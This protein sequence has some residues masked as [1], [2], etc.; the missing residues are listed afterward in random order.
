LLAISSVILVRQPLTAI[1]MLT[2]AAGYAFYFPLILYLSANFSFHWALL[3]AVV[4][5]GALLVNYARWLLPGNFAMLGAAV[6]LLLYQLFPT[7]AAFAGWNRG[8]VLLCLG[9]VTLAVLINLQNRAL[10]QKSLSAAAVLLALCVSPFN[11]KGA[12]FQVTLPAELIAKLPESNL[13][14]TNALVAFE[15][16]QYQIRHQPT[17]LQVEAQLAV[18]VVRAGETPVPLFGAPVH[19][20]TGKFESAEADVARL[21]TYTNRLGLLAQ[22]TGQGSLRLTYRVPVENR[23]GKKRAQI[24]LLLGPSGNVWLESSRADLEFMTGSL[25]TKV[26]TDQT[27][28]YDLGVAGEESLVIEWRDQGGEMVTAKQAGA[29]KEF[30]GIGLTRAQNLTIVN[31]DGSCTHFA[32]FELPVSQADEFRLRLPANSRLISVSV[33]GA[34]IGSPAVEDQL[35]RFRLPGREAQQTAH[36]LSFRIAYPPMRLGFIGMA[37]LTLP[38]VFQT[39]GTLEWVVALPNGFDAQVIS[40]GLETRK[41]APDLERFGD[42]GRILKSQTHTYLAKSLAPPGVVNLS[43]KYRQLV[44]GIY[45][46]RTP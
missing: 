23:E 10:K 11:A 38:E 22:Q 24:P 20:Q 35:C 44:S 32:E 17:H 41:I 37:E 16:A 34:E 45:E 5:P 42:Y 28:I 43:L 36:R 8:M 6:F 29:A 9:V 12:E 19:L 15:P 30:Y 40:S 1:Q 39:A 4:V 27:T 7:L 18:Q 33:N 13:E 21:V 31:S 25:W 14:K 3:I 46:A 2:I 26:T